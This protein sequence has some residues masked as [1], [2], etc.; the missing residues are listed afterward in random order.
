MRVLLESSGGFTGLRMRSSLDTE[1]LPPEQ[2]ADA[3]RA[4][5]KLALMPPAL[6]SAPLPRYRLTITRDTGPQVVE[7]AETRVPQALRP[8]ISAL[9]HRARPNA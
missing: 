1:E 5:E 7:L 8:L 9:M 4:L 2:A 6:P 3:V